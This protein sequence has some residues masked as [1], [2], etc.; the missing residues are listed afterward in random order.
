MR[1]PLAGASLPGTSRRFSPDPHPG[2]ACGRGYPDTSPASPAPAGWGQ[3]PGVYQ[4]SSRARG[5]AGEK[6][7][8]GPW[9]YRHG[10]WRLAG[11]GNLF[12]LPCLP[13]FN[14][15]T[16]HRH[17]HPASAFAGIP[18]PFC[19]RPPPRQ[20]L[21][22][23]SPA[24]AGG[25]WQ[26]VA[27]SGEQP[28]PGCNRGEAVHW[29]VGIS[30]RGVGARGAGELVPPPLSL[31]LQAPCFSLPAFLRGIRDTRA[32][33]RPPPRPHLRQGDTHTLSAGIPPAPI[34]LPGRQGDIRW[35]TVWPAPSPALASHL[36][37]A[38]VAIE[39]GRVRSRTTILF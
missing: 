17:P 6:P 15:L 33:L 4:G 34:S 25:R 22:R 39:A 12:P 28:Y 20:R 19:R 7:C 16:S 8:T 30:P 37:V 32:L 1:I 24:P 3:C 10:G 31:T 9:G 38:A 13:H 29:T 36:T 5:V 26:C 35:A 14:H 2:R 27:I 18:I 21:R 11:R 23:S